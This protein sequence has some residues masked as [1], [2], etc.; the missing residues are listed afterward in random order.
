M[1]RY[2]KENFGGYGFD[3]FCKMSFLEAFSHE[4]IVLDLLREQHLLFNA[5]LSTKSNFGGEDNLETE[6]T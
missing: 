2:P 4:E 1:K 6:M 3:C 5:I